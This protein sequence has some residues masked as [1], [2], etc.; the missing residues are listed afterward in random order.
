MN[1]KSAPLSANPS[2]SKNPLNTMRPKEAAEFLGVSVDALKKLRAKNRG[3]KYYK[4][5][6]NNSRIYY[7]VSDLISWRNSKLKATKE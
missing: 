4:F 7:A 3:P 1:A 2:A 6:E 5:G